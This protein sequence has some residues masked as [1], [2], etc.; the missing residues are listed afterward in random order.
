MLIGILPDCL[1][2]GALQTRYN[3]SGRLPP[4]HIRN[5]QSR[6]LLESKGNTT[7]VYSYGTFESIIL[8]GTLKNND[9]TCLLHPLRS[10]ACAHTYT[11]LF[12]FL[13]S[14]LTLS[15]DLSLTICLAFPDRLHDRTISV[16]MDS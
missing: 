7:G 4:T 5:W 3:N 13:L 2:D 1:P 9:F 11:I 10:Y 8:A 16:F 6:E 12:L 15:I 14:G